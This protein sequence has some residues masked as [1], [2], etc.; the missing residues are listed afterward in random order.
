M[1]AAE[2]E[3]GDMSEKL[4]SAPRADACAHPSGATERHPHR[5]RVIRAN[6]T[7]PSAIARQ[8][9]HLMRAWDAN[10]D[11]ALLPPA[12]RWAAPVIIIDGQSGSGKSTLTASLVSH[13]RCAGVRNFAVTSPDLWFPGWEGLREASTLTAR[14][15][16]GHPALAGVRPP[17]ASVSGVDGMFTWDWTRGRWGKFARMDRR[18]PLIVEGSGSLTSLVAA[19]ASLRM[20]VETPGGEAVRQR[21]AI[22]R[23]G[24]M[25]APWWR[26]WADQEREHIVRHNPRA[27]ADYIIVNGAGHE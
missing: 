12:S 14:L 21:R 1:S 27:L 9:V 24:D 4:A 6:S 16:T 11:P 25:F 19:V 2:F 17:A 20:W 7:F 15:L 3:A 18:V 5:G 10:P 26:V 13:L 8:V 23:D 22:E